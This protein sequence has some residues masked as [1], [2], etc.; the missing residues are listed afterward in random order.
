MEI[1]A[2]CAEHEATTRDHVPPKSIFPRPRPGNLITV[3]ACAECNNGASDLDDLF[4]VYLSMQAAANSEIAARLF[5]EK[6]V[7]TLKRNQRLLNKLQEE[8]AQIEVTTEEGRIETRTG[9][10]WDSVA[11]DAVIERTIRGLY[12][13]HWGAPLTR[14][15]TL[16][17]QWLQTIPD[18]V[19][20]KISLFNEVALGDD[21]V[22]YKYIISTDDP[23]FSLW[24]FDFY[25]AHWAS[26]YT[27]PTVI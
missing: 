6:T 13:H 23:R 21:Q 16:S 26:G 7:R 22:V 20:E 9:Y 8:S 1:C 3:P 17:V 12:W 2:I 27:Q 11:H 4:K 19:L 15:A 5:R 25:G 24:F 18:Q 10:L 14:D